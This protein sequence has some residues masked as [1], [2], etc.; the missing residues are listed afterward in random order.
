MQKSLYSGSIRKA[1][2]L[3]RA[4]LIIVRYLSIAFMD[5]PFFEKVELLMG[6]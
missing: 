5:K 3:F 1:K 4:S 6:F 2:S